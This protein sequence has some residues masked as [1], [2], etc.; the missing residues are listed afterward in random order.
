MT[1]TDATNGAP[2]AGRIQVSG[3]GRVVIDPD[4]AEVRLGVA[5]ARSTV[6]TAR[7]DGSAAMTAI[8]AAIDAAGVARRDVRTTLLR[9]SR[10]TTTATAAPRR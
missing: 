4:V 1:D 7:A 8:L 10:A 3:T 5:V 9:C 6:A 2:E